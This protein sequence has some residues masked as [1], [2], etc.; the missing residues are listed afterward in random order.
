R[1]PLDPDA[2]Q[3]L[4]RNRRHGQHPLRRLGGRELAQHPV[5]D[6][7]QHLEAREP[8]SEPAASLCVLQSR[9]GDDQSWVNPRIEHRLHAAHA[10]GEEE[11]FFFPIFSPFQGAQPLLLGTAQHVVTPWNTTCSPG[12]WGRHVFSQEI[13]RR[14]FLF[15]PERRAAR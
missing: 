2:F 3:L 14:W 15:F 7:A 12:Y 4:P 8:L 1:R 9:R 11:A 13:E 10:L 5:L 6:L